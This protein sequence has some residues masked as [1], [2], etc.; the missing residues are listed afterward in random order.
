MGETEHIVATLGPPADAKSGVRAVAGLSTIGLGVLAGLVLEVADVAPGIDGHSGDSAARFLSH[1]LSVAA[2]W[3]A[4]GFGLCS[5]ERIALRLRPAASLWWRLGLALP[6]GALLAC[7]TFVGIR[8]AACLART[9]CLLWHFWT[10]AAFAF[11]TN[12]LPRYLLLAIPW[13]AFVYWRRAIVDVRQEATLSAQRTALVESATQRAEIDALQRRI[14]PHFL[15]NLLAHVAHLAGRDV[16]AAAAVLER[17][18][19]YVDAAVPTLRSESWTVGAE[20]SLLRDYE[21][22]VHLRFGSRLRMVLTVP[23]E[24]HAIKLPPL[25]ILT[26]VENAIK[27]GLEP[28]AGHGTVVVEARSLPGAVEIAVLDDGVGLESA[29]GSGTGLAN[30]AARLKLRDGGPSR[31]S[32]EERPSGGVSAVLRLSTAKPM[33]VERGAWA[34]APALELLTH[35]QLL[36]AASPWLGLGVA[37]GILGAVAGWTDPRALTTLGLWLYVVL[38]P[39]LVV[40]TALLATLVLNRRRIL[41]LVQHPPTFSALIVLVTT[42]AMGAVFAVDALVGVGPASLER[43]LAAGAGSSYASLFWRNFA[44]MWAQAVLFALLFAWLV[45]LNVQRRADRQF[46]QRHR[47]RQQAFAARGVQRRLVQLRAH[48][49]WGEASM[50]LRATADALR[51]APVPSREPVLRLA[52]FLRLAV[53]LADKPRTSLLDE[54]RLGSEYLALRRTPLRLSS[55]D[56]ADRAAILPIPLLPFLIELGAIVPADSHFDLEVST[57]TAPLPVGL[58]LRCA[59]LGIAAVRQALPRLRERLGDL[60]A[61]VVDP[62]GTEGFT[63]EIVAHAAAA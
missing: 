33:P 58:R 19:E 40:V 60:A 29:A 13:L 32:I 1:F 25:A 3:G 57:T 17:L 12:V 36:A 6:S 44:Q 14:E 50:L 38:V 2:I 16:A 41:L 59:G 49:G 30:L 22:L 53:R 45:A 28:R 37:S 26:L 27:H 47:E 20:L 54:V 15:L 46:I 63:L 51:A 5:G 61:I 42:L 48:L 52:Q 39:T 7:A 24:L 21:A 62:A 18:A 56:D 11:M 4:A 43:E 55:P 31:L 9:T 23:P 34:Q 35:R 10:D 8:A